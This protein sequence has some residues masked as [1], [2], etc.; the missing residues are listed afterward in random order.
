[1][2]VPVREHAPL[3]LA[4]F[5]W[6]VLACNLGV[7]VWGAYVR[8]TG[9]GAG[10]GS[11]WPLCNGAILPR[12]AGAAT[13]IEYS[14]RLT[15]GIAL[16]LVVA[17]VAWVWRA[18]RHGHPARTGAALSLF[19]MLT[20][21]AV[22]AGLVLFEL[23][24]DNAST[25]RALFMAVHLLNTFVLLAWLALTAW[26]LSGGGRPIRRGHGRTLAAVAAGCAA[27]LLVGSSG[28]VAALGDT[29]FPSS[30]LAEALRADVSVTSHALI[31]LRVLHPVLAVG[32]ALLIVGLA[33][34]VARA[35]RPWSAGHGAHEGG[36]DARPR[37][38][39]APALS[40]AVVWLTIAQLGLGLLNVVL[41]APVWMQL[42]HLLVADAIWI[43]FVLLGAAAIAREPA[44]AHSGVAAE[45]Q[46][47]S[48]VHLG[49][50]AIQPSTQPSADPPGGGVLFRRLFWSEGM[51]VRGGRR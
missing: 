1:M 16:L 20:E 8:A 3:R 45:P 14:H 21:A 10:C 46:A 15:S 25:A 22:G 32:A 19:F 34:R 39:G 41:L 4:R 28:A 29:L 42:V 26:W 6:L 11:H 37:L 17:L 44:A 7:I 9:S 36:R 31:R 50:P 24:A 5:A 30:S 23:V 38:P 18:C 13:L 47:D 12:S 2:I 51:E 35:G 48:T 49:G 40:R 27:L 33:P 43:G